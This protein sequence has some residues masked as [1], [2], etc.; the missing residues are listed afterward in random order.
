MLNDGKPDQCLSASSVGQQEREGR[1][2]AH[3]KLEAAL[4]SFVFPTVQLGQND[5]ELWR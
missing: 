3:R 2:D 1:C 5:N 4:F